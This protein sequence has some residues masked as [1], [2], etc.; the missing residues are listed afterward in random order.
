MHMRERAGTEW[1]REI[2]NALWEELNRTGVWEE[3]GV[4]GD[5]MGQESDQIWGEGSVAG[6]SG[7]NPS[8]PSPLVFT[9]PCNPLLLSVGRSGPSNLLLKNRIGRWWNVTSWLG[10]KIWQLLSLS[11]SLP[12]PLP[13]RE[14]FCGKVHREGSGQQLLRNWDSQGTEF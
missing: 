2:H 10:S 1:V 8:D 6:S 4:E 3:V 9:P 11:L 12:A 14:M 13:F 7:T 5:K